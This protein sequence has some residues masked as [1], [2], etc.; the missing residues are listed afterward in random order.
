MHVSLT[1]ELEKFVQN[2]V[3][4]GDYQTASEV[5]RAG[6]RLLKEGKGRHAPRTPR[7]FAELE[8]DLMRA[9]DSL[10]AG[11]GEDGR[12]VMDQLIKSVK[13]RRTNA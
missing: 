9:A 2:E 8:A 3:S 6:L 4:A 11:E 10:D 7:T 5:I 1:P 13:A 12:V